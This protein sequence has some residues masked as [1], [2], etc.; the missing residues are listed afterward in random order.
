MRNLRG[1]TVLL[2]GAASGIGRELALQLAAEG[3]HLVLI[4]R[5]PEGLDQV[6]KSAETSGSSVQCYC[7]DLARP[8]EIRSTMEQVLRD[9]CVIDILINNAGVAWYGPTHGMSQ[10][11]WDWLMAVNL[12]APIQIT[13]TLLPHLLTRPDAH[14]VNMCSISGLVAGGRFAAYHTSKFGLIGFTESLR[15]E[16]SRSGVGVSAI[17]PGPV[18]TNLYE[19]AQKPK[20]GKAVPQPPAIVCATPQ[21]VASLTIRAIRRNRRMTLI[22]PMAHGLFQ[23]KRF[24]PGLLDA[25]S[26]FSRSRKRRRQERLKMEEA[27]LA[28]LYQDANAADTTTSRAA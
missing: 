19:A 2:T 22:T 10:E 20:D 21:R 14:I 16:Y 5:N 27:R 24:M 12:L 11:Q 1:K 23:L 26:R 28:A 3:C 25:V 18:T 7:C 13:Q 9:H 17:C 4:D 6:A 15:A 8:D